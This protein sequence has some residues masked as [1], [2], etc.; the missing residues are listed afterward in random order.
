MVVMESR[1]SESSDSDNV[2]ARMTV[3]IWV[4]ITI[5]YQVLL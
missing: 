1:Y 5:Q 4:I 3:T 2:M